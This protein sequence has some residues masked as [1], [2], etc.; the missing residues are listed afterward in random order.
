[1]NAKNFKEFKDP[2]G[3]I[4]KYDPTVFE[5]KDDNYL[6][7][8]DEYEGPIDLPD[9]LTSASYMFERCQIKPGCYLRSFNTSNITDMSYMFKY[10]RMP[11]NFSLGDNFDTSNVTNMAYMFNGC[12]IPADFVLNNKFD[13]IYRLY[14]YVRL[15]RKTILWAQ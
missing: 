5:I 9:D 3:K 12:I 8:R 10:C 15:R 11:D 1:M 14:I 4:I 2:S 6:H 7:F 13:K